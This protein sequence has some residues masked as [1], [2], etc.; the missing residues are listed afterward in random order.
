[1][2]LRSGIRLVTGFKASGP[3]QGQ[4]LRKQRC[5]LPLLLLP[6]GGQMGHLDKAWPPQRRV[7]R[8]GETACL[9]WVRRGSTCG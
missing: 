2:G 3:A 9:R 4:H 8:V 5:L 6:H 7:Q 1:M